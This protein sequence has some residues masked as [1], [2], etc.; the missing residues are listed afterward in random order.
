MFLLYDLGIEKN[1]S[2]SIYGKVSDI[3]YSKYKLFGLH[4]SEIAYL[5][6]INPPVNLPEYELTVKI[7]FEDGD[8]RT[9]STSVAP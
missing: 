6:W 1:S 7:I 4:S 5:G 8:L 2:Q 3:D 9:A